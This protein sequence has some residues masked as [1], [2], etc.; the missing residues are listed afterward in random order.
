MKPGLL[1]ILIV[2][3]I[4]LGIAYCYQAS[5]LREGAAT[6]GASNMFQITGSKY[7]SLVQFQPNTYD[8]LMPYL[9]RTPHD[10]ILSGA[11]TDEWREGLLPLQ[12]CKDNYNKPMFVLNL[13]SGIQGVGS[14][15]LD[16]YQL[17]LGSDGILGPP[18]NVWSKIDNASREVSKTE[19]AADKITITAGQLLTCHGPRGVDGTF[20]P[21][22]SNEADEDGGTMWK[23]WW[24]NTP[25]RF[26]ISYKSSSDATAQESSM[27][28]IPDK[29]TKTWDGTLGWQQT[30]PY[31]KGNW[32]GSYND[33]WKYRCPEHGGKYA[34]YKGCSKLQYWESYV[35]KWYGQPISTGPGTFTYKNPAP[36]PKVPADVPVKP[37]AGSVPVTPSSQMPSGSI[38]VNPSAQAAGKSSVVPSSTSINVPKNIIDQ[39]CEYPEAYT[40]LKM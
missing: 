15:K 39:L 31:P 7:Y 3:F 9:K 8:C 2:I 13:N 30:Q 14:V 5:K 35:Q 28:F 26:T 6:Q 32:W 11:G 24:R 29:P 23:V 34:Q 12:T 27:Y 37:S 25:L 40:N 10:S 16:V 4:I 18:P 19:T 36:P 33:A 1:N 17:P 38:T 20:V 22:T 21:C